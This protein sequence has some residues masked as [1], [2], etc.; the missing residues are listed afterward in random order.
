MFAIA[1]LAGVAEGACNYS[2]MS[3]IG[4][5]SEFG[6]LPPRDELRLVSGRVVKVDDRYGTV[7]VAV[8]PGRERYLNYTAI[9]TVPK[10]LVSFCGIAPEK[11]TTLRDKQIDARM[12]RDRVIVELHIEGKLCASYENSAAFGEEIQQ[13]RDDTLVE[14]LG[15]FVLG[16][17]AFGLLGW[18]SDRLPPSDEQP[19]S[20]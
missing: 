6:R 13:S 2:V 7:V 12:L 16:I 5:Y 20:D 11:M 15:W 8:S 4:A 9:P 19:S 17:V 10:D 14:A 18:L 1:A 3:V